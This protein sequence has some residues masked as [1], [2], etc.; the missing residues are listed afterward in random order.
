MISGLFCASVVVPPGYRMAVPGEPL[1]KGYIYWDG[2]EWSHGTF[3]PGDFATELDAVPLT[4]K[5]P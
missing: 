2:C 5:A 3:E 4:N 1:P